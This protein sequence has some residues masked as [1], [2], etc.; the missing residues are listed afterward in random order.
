MDGFGKLRVGVGLVMVVVGVAL[1][2]FYRDTEFGWFTGLPLGIAV[3]ALGAFDVTR[4][5]RRDV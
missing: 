5:V 1:I 3:L 2:A 4:A